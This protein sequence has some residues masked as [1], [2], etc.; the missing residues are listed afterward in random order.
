MTVNVLKSTSPCTNRTAPTAIDHQNEKMETTTA[1]KSAWNGRR[2]KARDTAC[3]LKNCQIININRDSRVDASVK[4]RNRNGSDARIRGQNDRMASVTISATQRMGTTKQ[5][6]PVD[7]TAKK[8]MMLWQHLIFVIQGRPS[9]AGR[10]RWCRAKW[11]EQ[12]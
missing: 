7:M 6:K 9:R 4:E 2:K 10:H 1:K 12:L 8:A 5:K 11:Q 3:F